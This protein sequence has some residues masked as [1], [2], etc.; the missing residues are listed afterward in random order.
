MIKKTLAVALFIPL[1]F[2]G[3]LEVII[4]N[5]C[6]NVFCHDLLSYLIES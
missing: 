4:S 6:E 2:M 5:D 1:F 3:I